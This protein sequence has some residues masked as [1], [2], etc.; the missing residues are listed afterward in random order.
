MQHKF[1]S[2]PDQRFL[3]PA[4][5]LLWNFGKTYSHKEALLY[6][7]VFTSPTNTNQAAFQVPRVILN[8]D[9]MENSKAMPTCNIGSSTSTIKP[10][11][12]NKMTEFQSSFFPMHI[13]RSN[14]MLKYQWLNIVLKKTTGHVLTYAWTWEITRY[15]EYQQFCSH[16][17]VSTIWI[18]KGLVVLCNWRLASKCLI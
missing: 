11:K 9:K 18:L 15:A 7:Q 10:I 14:F 16:F 12:G 8:L 17:L 2:H 4:A 6:K 1:L 3:L 13:H 5:N